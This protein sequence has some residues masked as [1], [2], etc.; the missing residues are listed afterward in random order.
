VLVDLGTGPALDV[1][2]GLEHEPGPR[3]TELALGGEAG[4]EGLPQ[5]AGV[6]VLSRDRGG[7]LPSPAV[8]A[9]VVGALARRAVVVL[10]VGATLDEP[11]LLGLARTVLCVTPRE[12]RSAAGALRWRDLHPDVRLVV[13]GPGPGGL[14]ALELAHVTDLPLAAAGR[15]DRRLASALEHGL[16]PPPGGPLARLAARVVAEL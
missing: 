7:G 1:H 10:D 8:R 15:A 14:G 16:G 11:G 6:R 4:P 3:W 12:V 5:W 9:E 13:R 2:L